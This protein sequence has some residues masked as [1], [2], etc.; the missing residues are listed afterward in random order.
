MRLGS[1]AVPWN[2]AIALFDLVRCAG[3]SESKEKLETLGHVVLHAVIRSGP[4]SKSFLFLIL[5]QS[6]CKFE[7]LRTGGTVMQ[8]QG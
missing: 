7:R 2:A 6:P 3:M 5:T 1:G 4:Q 8:A